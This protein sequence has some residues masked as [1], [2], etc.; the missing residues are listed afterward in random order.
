M[1]ISGC[2]GIK[3]NVCQLNCIDTILGLIETQATRRGI[4]RL[5]FV[6]P[7]DRATNVKE[8]CVYCKRQLRAYFDGKRQAFH[9]PVEQHDTYFKRS[10][11]MQLRHMVRATIAAFCNSAIYDLQAS[12]WNARL[13]SPP[14]TKT[15]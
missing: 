4:A 1:W 7:Q 14:K 8:L 9:F 11:W 6:E 15:R 5:N 10:I 12:H 13:G 2:I 3:L